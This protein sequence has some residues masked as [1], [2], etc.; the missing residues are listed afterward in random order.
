MQKMSGNILKT[1]CLVIEIQGD[2]VVRKNNITM[3]YKI[4]AV[5]LYFS[6]YI[7]YLSRYTL[8]THMTSLTH[9]IKKK[10]KCD[11]LVQN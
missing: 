2:K 4:Y 11:K 1:K 5:Y 9:L 8:S 3:T 6:T 10:T 7:S